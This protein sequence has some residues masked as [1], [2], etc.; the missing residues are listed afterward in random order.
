MKMGMRGAAASVLI[1][2]MG[3]SGVALSQQPAAPAAAKETATLNSPKQK[4]GYA[5]GLDVAKSFTPIADEIDVAALRTA[6]ERSFEGL[7]PQITQEQAKATD[8]ALRQ[9]V[10]ARSGQQVPGMAPGSQPP[11]VDRVKVSQMIGSYSVGPSLAQL[12]DDIDVASLFDA[13]STGL[14]KGQPKMTEA[15]ATATIQAL[16]RLQRVAVERAGQGA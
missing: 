16:A 1:L 15:D 14:S 10:M 4:L 11:K 7:Q 3:T 6:V 9:V 2:A 8:A 5:I 13:I 12:K